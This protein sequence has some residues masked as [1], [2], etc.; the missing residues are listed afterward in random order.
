[1]EKINECI[2]G[3]TPKFKSKKVCYGHGEFPHVGWIEC[4]CGLRTEE[5]IIDGFYGCEDTEETVIRDWN[6]K[7]DDIL[8]RAIERL[9]KENDNEE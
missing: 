5:T 2:C 3:R 1:M 9:R 8:I 7:M 6:K 4:K